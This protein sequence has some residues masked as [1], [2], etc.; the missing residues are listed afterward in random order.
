M[1][2]LS[3]LMATFVNG[4]IIMLGVEESRALTDG[5]FFAK[6]YTQD[7]TPHETKGRKCFISIGFSSDMEITNKHRT[8]AK[9]APREEVNN[10]RANEWNVQRCACVCV[11]M[12]PA[13][14][15]RE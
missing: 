4:R 8:G 1:H 12:L 9:R 13:P 3:K 5:F 2:F 6:R 10:Q 11:C 15:I 7:S 14:P